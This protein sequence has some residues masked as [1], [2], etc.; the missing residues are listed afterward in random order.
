MYPLFV[1]SGTATP[2]SSL[3]DA[4]SQMAQSIAEGQP[5]VRRQGSAADLQ[6]TAEVSRALVFAPGG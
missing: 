6:H 3:E 1:E 4:I 5:M 2:A